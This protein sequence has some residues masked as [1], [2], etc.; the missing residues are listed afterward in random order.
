[1][2]PLKT[3][4]VTLNDLPIT[5]TNLDKFSVLIVGGNAFYHPFQHLLKA[6]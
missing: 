1:M 6:Y 3:V 4:F 2:L 5:P